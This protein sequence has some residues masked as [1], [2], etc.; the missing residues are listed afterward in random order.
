[1]QNRKSKKSIGLSFDELRL[2]YTE[3]PLLAYYTARDGARLPY[4]HYPAQSEKILLLLHGSSWHSRYFM[5][6]AESLSSANIAQVY[7][8]DLRGHGDHPQKRGDV[9]Y[10]GQYED[11]L[12]D[13]IALI[14]HDN[15]TAKLILG[16]HSSG[17]GL[18]I[19]FAGGKGRS[20]V[21]ACL[22][23]APYLHFLAPTFRPAS[24][25]WA[26]P[27]GWNLLGVSLLNL[28]GIRRFNHLPVMDFNIPVEARDGAETT[29]YSYAVYA[30]L[31]PRNYKRELPKLPQPLLL[32]AGIED[33]AFYAE[34]YESTIS[35]Y[36]QNQTLLLD[37]LKHM[38]LVVSAAL[39][40]VVKEWLEKAF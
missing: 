4:R 36:A 28:L 30:S 40:P 2:D 6:L 21:D 7:T 32:V 18:V 22:L 38:E 24:G 13:L 17:G 16:G 39:R 9:E 25:G 34:K 11:D 1:M 8:P 10:I 31:S 27:R 14:R 3:I 5:P 37:N 12:I 29:S 33:E 35:K 15:P 26:I 20:L 19:R 23:L